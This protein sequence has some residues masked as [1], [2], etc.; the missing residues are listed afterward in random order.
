MIRR[1]V[2]LDVGGT[3]ARACAVWCEDGRWSHG[4]VT[5]I[6]WRSD[7]G[8]VA[9]PD[10][11]IE[12][13]DRL[14]GACAAAL[15][16]DPGRD[17]LD[18][19]AL[20][21]GIAGQLGRSG[22]VMRNA[23]NL[24]WRDLELA[25]RFAARLGVRPSFVNDVNAILLGELHFGAALGASDALAVYWGTG[26]G[27]ALAV[28]GRLVVGAGGNAGEI[29]HAKLVG[30]SEPCGCGE[31]GCVEA[32]AGGAAI[33]RRMASDPAFAELRGGVAGL[34]AAAVSDERA[35]ALRDELV[36]AVAHVVASACTVLN[37]E[38]LLL[39]GGV[40]ERAPELWARTAERIAALT[41]AVCR[42]DLSIRSGA[43]GD[44][45]GPL[46]AGA[47]ALSALAEP[48]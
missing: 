20:G 24:G 12:A 13:V 43:L 18:G 40:V 37:P 41:L 45:A 10:E 9:D 28:G 33:L 25:D 39:G 29:G 34:C 23:P 6:A 5:K 48:V 8:A 32:I 14:R 46:G 38:V 44:V 22:T 11:L 27:G 2:G 21:I 19:V 26:I 3:H 35:A 16:A 47:W 15:P 36:E 4:P 7:D 30:R 31:R 17:A 1:A 42:S